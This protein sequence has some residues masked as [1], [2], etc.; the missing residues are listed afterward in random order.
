MKEYVEKKQ[1]NN[2]VFVIA[3]AME[4]FQFSH[5]KDDQNFFK[6][7]IAIP[8]TSGTIDYITLVAP[9]RLVDRKKDYKGCAVPVTGRFRSRNYIDETGQHTSLYLEAFD[10]RCMN[11]DEVFAHNEIYLEGNICKKG[12]YRETQ[13]GK[14]VMNAI[15]AVECKDDGSKDYLPCMFWNGN[16]E[17]V[18]SMMVG[19]RI[20]LTGRIQSQ[21]IIN[22]ETDEEKLIFKISAAKEQIVERERPHIW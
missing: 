1:S 7:L 18:N 16:A 3:E 5:R 6:A 15:L 13:G 9:E 10:M 14:K 20:R 22:N 4:N 2:E 17:R 19:T 11:V 12:L 21:T 8:R